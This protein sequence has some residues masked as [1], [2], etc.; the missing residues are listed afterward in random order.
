MD[1]HLFDLNVIY[2]TNKLFYTFHLTDRYKGE[3]GEQNDL[4]MLAEAE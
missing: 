2:L 3:D 4:K 1:E